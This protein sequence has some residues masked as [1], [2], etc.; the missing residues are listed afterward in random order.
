MASCDNDGKFLLIS[1]SENSL[2]ILPDLPNLIDND[3]NS[4]SD[5]ENW[6]E[7]EDPA[8]PTKCLFCC[9]QLPS[10]D[11]AI[12]HLKSSHDFDFK[13]IKADYSLDFYGYMKVINLV[14]LINQQ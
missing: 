6:V 5:E 14:A 12:A 7:S 9:T 10:I 2:N 8:E 3:N 1:I 13:K 11:E 4:D